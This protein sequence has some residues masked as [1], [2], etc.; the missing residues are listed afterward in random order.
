M[1]DIRAEAIPLDGEG[2]VLCVEQQLSGRGRQGR[3]W[4]S[5]EGG[6]YFSIM[7]QPSWDIH[8]IPKMTLLMSVVLCDVIRD[9]GVQAVIKWPNDILVGDQ[10]LAGIL[11]ESEISGRNIER[12]IVGVGLNVNNKVPDGGVSLKE[13]T[14]QELGRK[15]LLDRI[16]KKFDFWCER[17]AA[18]GFE[19]LLK[20]WRELCGMLGKRVRVLTGQG[21]ILGQAVD[22]GD[23][24]EL[25]I[26]NSFGEV[27]KVNSGDV[28]H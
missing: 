11:T 27:M 18:Q 24:G 17:V 23:G 10:K 6:L 7:I 26:S 19:E 21:E 20:R 25:L 1:D 4:V 12:I 8:H 16:L 22:I 9:K 3:E 2:V 5:R 28:S 15:D 14:G 13:L